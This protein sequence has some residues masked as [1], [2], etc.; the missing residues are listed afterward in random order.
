MMPN[1]MTASQKTRLLPPPVRQ[2]AERFGFPVDTE[3]RFVTL[4]QRGDMQLGKTKRC[5]P[6]SLSTALLSYLGS[7]VLGRKCKKLTSKTTFTFSYQR[8]ARQ[9]YPLAGTAAAPTVFKP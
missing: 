4:E 2:L 6:P 9:P 1:V 5:P 3:A 8:E 7:P